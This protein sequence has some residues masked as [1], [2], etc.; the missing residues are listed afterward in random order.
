MHM[1]TLQAL[2]DCPLRWFAERHGGADPGG[3]QPVLGSVL[4]AL[5]ADSAKGETQLV[6]E[7][8]TLVADLRAFGQRGLERGF[9]AVALS[10]AASNLADASSY[11][12]DG[13]RQACQDHDYTPHG[14]WDCR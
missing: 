5:V 7:L 6:A 12:A 1:A 2:T 10:A 9:T 3:L 4:H 11:D 8:E 13:I 14:V